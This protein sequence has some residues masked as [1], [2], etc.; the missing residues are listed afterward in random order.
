MNTYILVHNKEVYVG[1]EIDEQLTLRESDLESVKLVSKEQLIS[2]NGN[3]HY[4]ALVETVP[5]CAV[6]YDPT[7]PKSGA[8]ELSLKM[9]EFWK[10]LAQFKYTYP[11]EKII[12][13]VLGMANAKFC[14]EEV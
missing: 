12:D 11:E 5:A 1:I 6:K 14:T 2:L 3:N 10:T 8:V 7:K 4:V 13:Y 9:F